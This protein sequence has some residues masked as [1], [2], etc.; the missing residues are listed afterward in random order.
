MNTSLA[1]AL[2]FRGIGRVPVTSIAFLSL[3]SPITA[4]IVGWIALDQHLGALQLVGV[5]LALG[6]SVVGSLQ[7]VSPTGS[8]AASPVRP[9]TIGPCPTS[10]LTVLDPNPSVAM[11]CP[12]SVAPPR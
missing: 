10:P 6:A 9:P 8:Q 11:R 2:W 4:A 1:Y 5:A 7:T 12:G 3:L